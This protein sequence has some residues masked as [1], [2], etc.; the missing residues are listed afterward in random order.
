MSALCHKQTLVRRG[1]RGVA[2]SALSHCH[3]YV[4]LNFGGNLAPSM[5]IR[6]DGG[7]IVRCSLWLVCISGP[8]QL[9]DQAA[10]RS[11]APE[12]LSARLPAGW[13]VTLLV[14]QHALAGAWAT[15]ERIRAEQWSDNTHDDKRNYKTFHG[16]PLA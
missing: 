11:H 7:G 15:S 14:V 10:R 16:F 6:N 2:N 8:R 1:T 5:S 12:E 13:A 4:C 9:V 3:D